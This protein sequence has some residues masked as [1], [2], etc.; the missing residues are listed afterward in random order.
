MNN[1]HFDYQLQTSRCNCHGNLQGQS[2]VSSGFGRRLLQDEDHSESLPHSFPGLYHMRSGSS[3]EQFQSGPE[4]AGSL[5]S[6]RY[7]I[8]RPKCGF[9]FTKLLSQPLCESSLNFLRNLSYVVFLWSGNIRVLCQIAP[10]IFFTI[11]L[12]QCCKFSLISQS[13]PFLRER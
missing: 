1:F 3:P 8:A 10:R 6:R 13:C 9:R 11:F 12:V 7:G 5:Q 2:F 4:L